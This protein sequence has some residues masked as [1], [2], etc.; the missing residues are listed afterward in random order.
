VSSSAVIA[1]I[2]VVAVV[3]LATLVLVALRRRQPRL[4]IR[5]LPAADRDRYRRDFDAILAAT[6]GRPQQS[7]AQARGL[8]EEVL[9]RMGFPDRVDS[10]QKAR[11]VAAYDRQVARV[12]EQADA[13]IRGAGADQA[14][15]EH[16]VDLYRQAL[17]G[18]LAK[19]ELGDG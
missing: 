16:V 18:L 9:R 17:G 5:P 3:V 7:A 11:D 10:A 12:L 2:A 8:V 13:A 1:I 6:A 19:S 15:L 14:Q 4:D